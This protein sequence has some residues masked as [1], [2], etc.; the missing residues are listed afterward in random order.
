VAYIT[1]IVSVIPTCECKWGYQK[2]AA[3]VALFFGWINLIM[4]LQG[5]VISVFV[6]Q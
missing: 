4:Y 3:A 2:Q 6:T 1:A 5:L